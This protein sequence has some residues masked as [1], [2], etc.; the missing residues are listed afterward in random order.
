MESLSS[1]VSFLKE[2]VMLRSSDNG[3]FFMDEVAMGCYTGELP[4]LAYD[5]SERGSAGSLG[6]YFSKLAVDAAIHH[7]TTGI[8]YK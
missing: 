2:G 5:A 6:M 7:K 3:I 4:A 1:I 8:P